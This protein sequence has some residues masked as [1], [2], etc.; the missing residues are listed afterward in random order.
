MSGGEQG[1]H[2]SAGGEVRTGETDGREDKRRG[3]HRVEVPREPCQSAHIV[4]VSGERGDEGG[5]REG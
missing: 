4:V 3:S 2:G 1:G 5:Y